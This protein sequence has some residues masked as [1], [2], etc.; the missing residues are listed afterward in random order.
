MSLLISATV[1]W[2]IGNMTANWDNPDVSCR[3]WP[4]AVLDQLHSRYRGTFVVTGVDVGGNNVIVD[5][6][7]AVSR[8]RSQILAI[9]FIQCM[10]EF[11]GRAILGVIK[12]LRET[13]W[14][15]DRLFRVGFLSRCRF[16]KNERT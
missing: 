14:S 1:S 3:K 2:L 6:V 7:E 8:L 10:N 13:C 5:I 11:P 12:F 16:I 9:V 4:F 15:S